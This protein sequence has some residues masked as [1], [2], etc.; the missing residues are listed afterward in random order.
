MKD[1]MKKIVL[2]AAAVIGIS[3]FAFSQER[4]K[5]EETEFYSPVPPIVTPGAHF[6]D[7]PSDAIVLFDGSNLSQWINSKDSA[8][9]KW[10]LADNVM[11][12]NKSIGDIQTRS[13]F[14][15]YQLH[16]EYRIPSNITGSGQARGNS[17]IF[18][19]ALPWGPGGYELQVL[20][21]FKISH[22][23]MCHQVQ[24]PGIALNIVTQVHIIVNDAV[25][26]IDTGC[27]FA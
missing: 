17:G 6:G 9:A 26:V 22:L 13:S 8:A 24:Q 7:A 15:D 2:A 10:T 18:L 1:K 20:D 21:N 11:T 4:M 19:A 23:V 12:V 16:I 5:P 3:S 25:Q 14:T 27:I